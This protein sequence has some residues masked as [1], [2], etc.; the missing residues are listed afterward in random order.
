MMNTKLI[1]IGLTILSMILLACD[2]Q[3][4]KQLKF[5]LEFAKENK[6]ELKRT[7]K[8]YQNEPEKLNGAYFLI[9]NMLGKQAIDSNSVKKIQPFYDALIN[10][11]EKFGS[12]KKNVQYSICDSIKLFCSNTEIS[13]RYL[14]DIRI[15]SSNYLIHHIDK[16]FNLWHKYPW[17]KDIDTET[18]YKYILPY[19]TNNYHWEQ[20]SYFFDQK[21]ATLRDTI[22]NKS[23]TEVGKLIS[24]HIDT[25]FLKEW[26]IY[27]E[28]KE[29]LPTTF[30]NIASAQMGSCLEQNIYKITALRANG[31]PAV[32]NTHPGWANFSYSHF[33]TEII[34][35]RPIRKLYDNTQRAYFSEDDI[36]VSD[37]FWFNAYNPLIKDISPLITIDYCRTVSKIFRFNYEIQNNSLVLSAQEEIPALFRDPGIEDITDKYV[38]SKDIKVPLW[39]SSHSKRYIYLCCY[40]AG[41]WNPVNWSIPQKK[42]ASFQKMGVNV[43]YLPAYYDKG[44]IIPAGDA[45]ILTTKGE[46]KSLSPQ[47]SKTEKI[48]TFYTKIPYRLHTAL[49]AASTVG[50]RFYL[51][52]KSDLSDSIFVH[53]I[54]EPPFYIDT[55]KIKD[56]KKY[57]YIVCDFQNVYPI[58]E[59]YCIAEIKVFGKDEKIITGNWKGTKSR[60]KVELEN[61]TDE[62]RLSYYQPDTDE[63]QQHIIL[64][65]GQAHKIEKIEFYPRSDDNK[66]VTG[67]LYELFYWNG[68]WISLGRQQAKDDKLVYHDIPKNVIFR[69]HNHTQGNEHRPFTYENGKQVWW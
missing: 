3:N 65:M 31:I 46:L 27:E 14:Q 30:Q 50:T 1:N 67:E 69:I 20:A 28:Y 47:I 10:H 62:S 9:K 68:K 22:Q 41:N 53:E 17:C 52:N 11:V 55:F 57:R 23:Y 24:H 60:Y 33:W 48:A 43:L 21:Y 51:C 39:N 7:L 37:M 16:Y 4:D 32:L 66:I 26:P 6:Q 36:L 35:D 58:G 49:K 5:T 12:Y 56:N 29:L 2:S 42:Q 34:G 45:F 44:T 25:T 15:L 8:H 64:D 40:N 54:N 13:P 18:F 61:I 38:I 59:P 19:T 63:R